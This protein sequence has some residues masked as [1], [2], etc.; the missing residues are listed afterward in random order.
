MSE[1]IDWVY[2][3]AYLVN[4]EDRVVESAIKVS[5]LTG[6]GGRRVRG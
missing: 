2:S 6:G 5:S 3:S 1:D 4:V